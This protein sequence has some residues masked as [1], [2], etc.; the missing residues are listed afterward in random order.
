MA[1]IA[2]AELTTCRV[3]RD[4]ECIQLVFVDQQGQDGSLALKIDSISALIMTLPALANAA[5]QAQ[6]GD[7]SLQIVY[8]LDHFRLE[9][10]GGSGSRILTL[11]TPD[12]FEVAFAL[13]PDTAERLHA[14]IALETPR[15]VAL[16]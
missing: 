2:V 1:D 3:S 4:G 12:G 11:E 5:L 14:A 10:A 7:P 15:A 8:T 16:Q 13:T 6:H 9:V